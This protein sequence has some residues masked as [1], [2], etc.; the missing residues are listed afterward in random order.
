MTSNG[1][2]SFGD[3]EYDLKLDSEDGCVTGDMLKKS[4]NH[5]L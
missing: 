1:H 3:D 4:L 5:R 2:R